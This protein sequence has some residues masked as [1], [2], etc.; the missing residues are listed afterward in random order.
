MHHCP[1]PRATV[2]QD[3]IS[4]VSMNEAINSTSS[5]TGQYHPRLIK[6]ICCP[7]D[8]LAV[9]PKGLFVVSTWQMACYITLNKKYCC[10]S[11]EIKQLKSRQRSG[12]SGKICC[13]LF[14]LVE[15]LKVSTVGPTECTFHFSILTGYVCLSSSNSIK[16]SDICC[17]FTASCFTALGRASGQT[18]LKSFHE[19]L[20]GGW[21]VV[22][23]VKTMCE[24]LSLKDALY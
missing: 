4:S 15:L 2:F 7:M 5:H 22:S 24:A 1:V 8:G 17:S 11:L 16:C 12:S 9:T 6:F 13:G 3:G 21:N 20:G 19:G 18:L 14:W 23:H 10:L